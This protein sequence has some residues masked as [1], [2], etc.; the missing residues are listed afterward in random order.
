MYLF[1]FSPSAIKVLLG[2]TKR[3]EQQEGAVVLDVDGDAV[4]KHPQYGEQTTHHDIAVV[5]LPRSVEFNSTF[6]SGKHIFIV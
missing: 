3:T 6:S 2:V 5:R 1:Y 4:T